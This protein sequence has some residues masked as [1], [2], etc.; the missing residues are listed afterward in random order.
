MINTE[1]NGT[2]LEQVDSVK[3]SVGFELDQQLSF[4][5]HVDS[6]SKKISKRTRILNRIKSSIFLKESVCYSTTY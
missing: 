1:L 6:L 5:N 2:R 4:D 3:L